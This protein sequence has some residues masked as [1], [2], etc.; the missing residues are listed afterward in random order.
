MPYGRR[1]EIRFDESN[2]NS[3]ARST[4]QIQMTEYLMTKTNPDPIGNLTMGA[5]INFWHYVD[6]LVLT[7]LNIWIF[8][9]RICFGFRD[10]GF[11]FHSSAS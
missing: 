6:R 4:K 2:P 3:E 5:L 9:F 1:Q 11:V 8:E 10:S 7:V